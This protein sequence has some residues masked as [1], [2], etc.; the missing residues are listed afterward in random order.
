MDQVYLL[1]FEAILALLLFP[2][3][4]HKSAIP[5]VLLILQVRPLSLHATN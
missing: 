2:S 3:Y 5:L 1:W 4:V